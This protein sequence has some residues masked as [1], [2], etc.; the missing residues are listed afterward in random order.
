MTL[1]RGIS[2][3]LTFA[4]R[5]IASKGC[6]PE[7]LLVRQPKKV[8]ARL[9]H[10]L[11]FAGL[12]AERIAHQAAPGEANSPNP[13]GIAIDEENHLVTVDGRQVHLTPTEFDLLLHLYQNAGQLCR[14]AEIARAVFGAASASLDTVK[15]QL[16]THMDRL[17]FK[18][19]KDPKI[20]RYLL[21]VR[22]QGYKLVK[23]P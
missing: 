7:M 9:L 22:G 2:S 4:A 21:T 5:T 3:S 18:I 6:A 23:A 20:P 13:A 1:R 17:R 15:G 11:M 16:N 8:I 12:L 19:E 14:R 10:R